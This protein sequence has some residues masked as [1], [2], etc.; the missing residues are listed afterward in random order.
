MTAR[1]VAL[2]LT[3]QTERRQYGQGLETADKAARRGQIDRAIVSLLC[4]AG[5]RRSEVAVLQWRDIKLIN[6][7]DVRVNE[8]RELR[9]EAAK[10]IQVLHRTL[11]PRPD[12]TVVGLG[13]HQVNRR[14]KKAC[15]EAGLD[16]R[17]S[18][19]GRV[20]LARALAAQGAPREAIQRAGGWKGPAMVRQYTKPAAATGG[21]DT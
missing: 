11:N 10:A 5:L 19:D 14:F 12:D 7:G 1:E 6:A 15:A 21:S 20:G 16:G 4:H 2:L 9:G 17:T 18:H 8:T 13:K 3:H